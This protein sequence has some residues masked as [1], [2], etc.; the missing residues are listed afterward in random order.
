MYYRLLLLLT[1][2]PQVTPVNLKVLPEKRRLV[3]VS[4]S[5]PMESFRVLISSKQTSQNQI[6]PAKTDLHSVINLTLFQ[7]KN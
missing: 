3:L 2:S 5:S 4:L 6:Q 1:R 7:T